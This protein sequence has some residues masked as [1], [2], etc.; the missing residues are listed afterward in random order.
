MTGATA[1]GKAPP[2]VA[3]LPRSFEG[4]ALLLELLAEDAFFGQEPLARMMKVAK[5]QVGHGTHV[6]AFRDKRLIGYA[7]YILVRP[8]NGEA[9]MNGQAAL[10]PLEPKLALALPPDQR[11]GAL[12]VVATRERDAILPL[13]R[14]LRDSYRGYRVFFKREYLP[15]GREERKRTVRAV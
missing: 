6:A 3:R 11:A 13:L 1:G 5:A 4:L 10:Q 8:E 7:G 15:G 9:W 14:K 2:T 12:T